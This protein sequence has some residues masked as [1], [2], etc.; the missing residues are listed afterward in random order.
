[1]ITVRIILAISEINSLDSKSINF[2]LAFPQADL[3]EYIWMKPPIG[4]QVGVQTEGD[5]DKKYVLK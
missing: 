4:L 5:Y 2:V 3:K 1:M